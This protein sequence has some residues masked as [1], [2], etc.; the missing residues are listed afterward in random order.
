MKDY[1]YL[2]NDAYK[3]KDPIVPDENKLFN[4]DKLFDGIT[5]LYSYEQY[6]IYECKNVKNWDE[7]NTLIY[8]DGT[9]FS[10]YLACA[11]GWPLISNNIKNIFEQ[12]NINNIQYLPIKII[13]K[14]TNKI[15]TNYYV[16]NII[17]K[18]KN[19]YN[20]SETKHDYNIDENGVKILSIIDPKPVLNYEVVKDFDIFYLEGTTY[21]YIS[22]K[23]KKEFKKN[24]VTGCDFGKVFF[25]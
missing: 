20:L 13:N 22:E 8:S 23:I 3:P 12:L 2:M 6:F 21:L 14:I 19:G 4:M 16:L 1:F 11:L 10:D 9:V 7:N 17:T 24:K 18:L 5:N 25:S 15:N